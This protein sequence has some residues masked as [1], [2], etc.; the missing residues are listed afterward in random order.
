MLSFQLFPVS[1]LTADNL[2]IQVVPEHLELRH[3]LLD[4]AAISL[5]F[6][7]LQKEAGLVV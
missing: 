3:R 7:L 2:L 6:H 1:D 4:G 5:L